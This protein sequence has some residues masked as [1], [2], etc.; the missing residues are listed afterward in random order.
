MT[1]P[2][3]KKYVTKKEKNRECPE[4]MKLQDNIYRKVL[5]DFMLGGAP[6]G[7]QFQPIRQEGGRLAC[8][9][10]IGDENWQI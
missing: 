7:V 1:T 10:H 8:P 2:M 4:T 9:S 3:N 6:A 5:D